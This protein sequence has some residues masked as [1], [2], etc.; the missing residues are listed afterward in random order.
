MWEEVI[1]LRKELDEQ[2]QG[3]GGS[4]GLYVVEE[5]KI[6]CGDDVCD[7]EE[8]GFSCPSDCANLLDSYFLFYIVGGFVMM[9]GAM[10]VMFLPHGEKDEEEEREDDSCYEEEEDDTCYEEMEVRP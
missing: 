6:E 5:G 2:M 4:S 7:D 10:L 8:D 1:V 3:G 9:I